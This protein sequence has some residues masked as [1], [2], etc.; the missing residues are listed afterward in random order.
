VPSSA[1]CAHG[2]F[3]PNAIFLCRAVDHR[4]AG[5]RVNRSAASNSTP[6][7]STPSIRRIC[8]L[9]A[10]S[11]IIC[12]GRGNA[13]GR[14]GILS[15]SLLLLQ[16]LLGAADDKADKVRHYLQDQQIHHPADAVPWALRV[17]PGAQFSPDDGKTLA[18]GGGVGFHVYQEHKLDRPNCQGKN[19]LIINLI[20]R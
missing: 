4:R 1:R 15:A 18:R 8:D 5:H 13:S 2:A 9:S 16:P 20:L 12:V 7:N 11:A 10:I 3:V 19:P 14:D 6:S 17:E